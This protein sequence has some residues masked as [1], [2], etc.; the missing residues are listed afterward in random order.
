MPP[1]LSTGTGQGKRR[2]YLQSR[3]S[4]RLSTL[5]TELGSICFWH[6]QVMYR[7]HSLPRLERSSIR[8]RAFGVTNPQ[9]FSWLLEFPL[10]PNWFS[11]SALAVFFSCLAETYD[12]PVTLGVTNQPQFIRM[13]RHIRATCHIPQQTPSSRTEL[14]LVLECLIPTNGDC[15]STCRTL[16]VESKQ[17]LQTIIQ[18]H[19]NGRTCI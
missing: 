10:L 2:L 8:V 17:R 15:V 18:P 9:L 13:S 11:Q 14:L 6:P 16:S 5:P 1:W 12:P 3:S 19:R 7:L 4:R